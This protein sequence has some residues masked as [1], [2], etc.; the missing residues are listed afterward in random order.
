M[1]NVSCRLMF[2]TLFFMCKI[3]IL[4]VGMAYPN[5]IHAVYEHH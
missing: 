1:G 4:A 5:S 2:N 3:L